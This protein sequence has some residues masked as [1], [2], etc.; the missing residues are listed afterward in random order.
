MK[1]PFQL[2]DGE[3]IVTAYATYWSGPGW[4]NG[5][6]WV[7]VRARDGTLREECI[8]PEQQSREMIE[9]FG[10]SALAH[11]NMVGA[12]KRSMKGTP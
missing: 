9:H 12:V 1:K 5:T 2:A 3:S 4:S 7:I 6:L 10:Y 11:T 8:Q